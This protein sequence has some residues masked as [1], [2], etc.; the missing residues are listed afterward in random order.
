MA[1]AALKPRRRWLLRAGL[2]LLA[3]LVVGWFA[4]NFL[5]RKGLEAVVTE[6]TGFPLEIGSFR[7]GILDSRIDVGGMRLRNP[8]GFEDPRCLD[9]PRLV[10][11]PE[12]RTLFGRNIHVEEIVVD[13]EEVVV[14]KNA[15]GETNLERLR[16]LGGGGK[17]KGNGTKEPPK[18][19]PGEPGQPGTQE[20]KEPL[21]WRC[22]RLELTLRRMIYLDYSRMKD[23]KPAKEEFDLKV[24]HEEFRDIDGPDKIVRLI[25][26]RVLQRTKIR[27][28]NISVESLT[29]GLE[30]VVGDL[31]GSVEGGLKGIGKSIEGLLGGKKEEAPKKKRR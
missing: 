25:A 22:D 27:L 2:A 18:P 26:L 15:A 24:D 7:L 16:A 3:L 1:D 17:E 14:V 19:G 5:V 21:K 11:D 12:F 4:R 23:G 9:V 20:R 6:V 31:A 28:S 29:A 13:V 10:A 30:G 8:E